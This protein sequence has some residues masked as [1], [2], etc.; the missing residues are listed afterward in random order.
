MGLAV[1][2]IDGSAVASGAVDPIQTHLTGFVPR[3]DARFVVERMSGRRAVPFPEADFAQRTLTTM[4]AG[5]SAAAVLLV[6]KQLPLQLLRVAVR[7]STIAIA[8]DIGIAAW[9][10]DSVTFTSQIERV[11]P[12]FAKDFDPLSG[13]D[14]YPPPEWT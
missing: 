10:L 7:A 12:A 11:D 3:F 8:T 5:A 14:A 9:R 1:S 6:H 13:A 4:V 2:S